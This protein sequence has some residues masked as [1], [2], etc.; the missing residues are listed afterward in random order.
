MH[1]WSESVTCFY[2]SYE[3]ARILAKTQDFFNAGDFVQNFLTLPVSK[4][5]E[6]KKKRERENYQTRLAA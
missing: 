6:K 5:K 1:V 2:G 3:A 4:K